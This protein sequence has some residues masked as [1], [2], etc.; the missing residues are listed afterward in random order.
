MNLLLTM[1]GFI[2]IFKCAC[3]SLRRFVVVATHERVMFTVLSFHFL[4]FPYL[5]A[6][7]AFL[8]Q[9]SIIIWK[10]VEF[11]TFLVLCS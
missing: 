7:Q 1:L 9:L 5:S 8:L 4:N 11:S 10:Y 6:F 2:K 3:E